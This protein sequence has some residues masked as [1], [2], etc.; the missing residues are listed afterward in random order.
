MAWERLDE[1]SRGCR[2]LCAVGPPGQEQ[3]LTVGSVEAGSSGGVKMD[4]EELLGEEQ[5]ME[6][7]S[8]PL[9]GPWSKSL[10]A[11][12]PKSRLGFSLT[13]LSEQRL[14]LFGGKAKDRCLADLH[15]LQLEH[16]KGDRTDRTESEDSGSEAEA[17]FFA[18]D[19]RVA[20]G[21]RWRGLVEALPRQKP[22]T[23]RQSRRKRGRERE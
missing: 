4:F 13:P 9:R 11:F 2:A 8:R 19:Y 16:G 20:C 7:W 1:G 12:P 15:V 17:I 10:L 3:L 5:P 22:P 6:L 21:T 14:L 18:A 23:P